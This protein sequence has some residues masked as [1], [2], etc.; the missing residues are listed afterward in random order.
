ME[1]EVLPGSRIAING[2]A[3]HRAAELGAMN[4]QLMGSAGAGPQLEQGAA[5]R[6]TMRQ[7]APRLSFF[8]PVSTRPAA[9]GGCPSTTAQ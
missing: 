2:I 3:K 5:I 7:P 9:S 8:R 6:D 4:P 1:L